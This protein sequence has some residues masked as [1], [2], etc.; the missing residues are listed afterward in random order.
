M[1]S[2]VDKQPSVVELLKSGSS[3]MVTSAPVNTLDASTSSGFID[4]HFS[5]DASSA[6]IGFVRPKAS[7]DVGDDSLTGFGQ[8]DPSGNVSSNQPGR[9][10]GFPDASGGPG[11]GRPA[12]PV[13]APPSPSRNHSVYPISGGFGAY[14]IRK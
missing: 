2:G 8:A 6:G 7:A 5:A 10:D 4:A 13:A 1:P 3:K 11:T 14:G 9:N 12:K